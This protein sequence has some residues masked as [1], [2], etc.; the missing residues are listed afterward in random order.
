MPRAFAPFSL[1]LTSLLLVSGCCGGYAVVRTTVQ[2]HAELRPGAAGE[3][4]VRPGEAHILHY[5]RLGEPPNDCGSE[6]KY[7]EDLRIRVPSMNVGE[8]FVLGTE[9]VL[10]SYSRQQ[11]GIS[12]ASKSV[13]G[14]LKIN[15]RTAESVAVALTIKVTLASGEVVALDDEY[16]FYPARTESASHSQV[17]SCRF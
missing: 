8:T 10:V 6:V 14:T 2:D 9:G 17:V 15:G 7:L 3:G 13:T 5:S 11:G 12:V 4:E 1:A 16:A